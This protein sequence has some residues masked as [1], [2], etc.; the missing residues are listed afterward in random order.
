MDRVASA[1]VGGNLLLLREDADAF[2]RSPALAETALAVLPKWDSYTMGYAPDGRQR[3]VADRHLSR[4][5]TSVAGSPGA[6][7]GDG[8][9][10]ILRGGNAIANWSHRFD[11][12]RLEVTLNVW[13]ETALAGDVFDA[14]GE[15]LN[16]SSITVPAAAERPGSAR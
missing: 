9:P 6:T 1:T 15:L 5:Y 11:G 12:D 4:A 2:Q 8:V 13:D 7:S 16:A 3:F 10:L 14:V